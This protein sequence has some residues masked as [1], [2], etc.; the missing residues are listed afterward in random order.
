MMLSS[1]L[2]A[3]SVEEILRR[4]DNNTVVTTAHYT[5]TMVISLAGKVREKTFFGYTEGK[6][7]AYME[8]TAPARDYGTRILKLDDEM[9]LYIPAVE[10]ATKIAGHM[11]RQSMMGSDFSYEDVAENRRLEELYDAEIL[12]TDTV[13][14][15]PCYKLRLTAKVDEVTYALRVVWIDTDEYIALKTELYAKSGKLMK[16]ITVN[17]FRM[18]SG[19]NY[20]TRVRMVN[21]LRKDTY[22]ELIL[23]DIQLDAALPDRIFSKAHLERK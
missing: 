17:E 5:A 13:N 10:K 1:M 3:E 19:R 16:E 7:R 23:E 15:H 6:D 4:V 11:L 9:W 21:K 2:V 12:G 14:G 18:I 20:P 22:T 8:F